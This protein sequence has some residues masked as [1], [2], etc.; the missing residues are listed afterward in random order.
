MSSQEEGITFS[1]GLAGEAGQEDEDQE[2][3]HLPS[4]TISLVVLLVV[5]V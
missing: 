4:V 5:V 3:S 1:V 2:S